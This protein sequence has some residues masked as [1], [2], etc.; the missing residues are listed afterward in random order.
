MFKEINE[1]KTVMNLDITYMHFLRTVRSNT[2][3]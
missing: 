3:H 2:S 1:R